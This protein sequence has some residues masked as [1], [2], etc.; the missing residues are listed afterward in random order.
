MTPSEGVDSVG[1]LHPPKS[2]MELAQAGPVGVAAW[3]FVGYEDER[4]A[5]ALRPGKVGLWGSAR[6]RGKH[7]GDLVLF[8][9]RHRTGAEWVGWGSVI[10]PEERWRA[11]GVRVRCEGLADPPLPVL[12]RGTSTSAEGSSLPP[13][14]W[15]YREAGRELGLEAHRERTPY[16]DTQARDLRLGASDLAFLLRLQPGLESFGRA[17]PRRTD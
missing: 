10:E 6:S 17:P 1:D 2:L 13:H 16:L 14:V 12:P 11:F 9:Q 8:L 5:R 4:I 15:E 7:L 3:I